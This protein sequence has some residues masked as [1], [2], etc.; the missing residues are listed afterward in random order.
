MTLVLP[1]VVLWYLID[2]T[3]KRKWLD[4]LQLKFDR[5]RL[6]GYASDILNA[7]FTTK[8]LAVLVNAIHAATER[9]LSDLKAGNNNSPGPVFVTIK[10]VPSIESIAKRPSLPDVAESLRTGPGVP[11]R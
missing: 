5:W 1:S 4:R 2:H 3:L 8:S 9:R 7:D 6:G 11:W 10:K